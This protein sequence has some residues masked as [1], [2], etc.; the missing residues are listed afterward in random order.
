M[1]LLN[2]LYT[3]FVENPIWEAKV[4]FMSNGR[5]FSPISIINSS[6]RSSQLFYDST[7]V[8]SISGRIN[9]ANA[10]ITWVN[11]AYQTLIIY[12]GVDTSKQAGFSNWLFKN[13]YQIEE[14]IKYN[15]IDYARQRQILPGEYNIK[16]KATKVGLQDSEWSD[17]LNYSFVSWISQKFGSECIKDLRFGAD[18]V[19][20]LYFGDTLIYTSEYKQ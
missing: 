10:N 8:A 13:S 9:W 5:V 16:T 18:E 1:K 4:N 6:T 12:N 20:K 14:A 19:K 2:K 3:T 15:L 17:P 11:T 7:P